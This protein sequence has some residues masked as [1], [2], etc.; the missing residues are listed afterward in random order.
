[1]SRRKNHNDK[2]PLTPS[3]DEDLGDIQDEYFISNES[4]KQ[5]REDDEDLEDI[6]DEDKKCKGC[7]PE[8]EN[9]DKYKEVTYRCSNDVERNLHKIRK[10]CKQDTAEEIKQLKAETE[11][12]YHELKNLCFALDIK[13]ANTRKIVL[14][15]DFLTFVIAVFSFLLCI[16]SVIVGCGCSHVENCACVKNGI[17]GWGIASIVLGILSLVSSIIVLALNLIIRKNEANFGAQDTQLPNAAHK[18][19]DISSIICW[20]ITAVNFIMMVSI[21]LI[22]FCR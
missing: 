22:I 5:R 1:M 16:A 19:N 9:C 13:I 17:S 3:D 6:Q 8:C 20:T 7:R 15:T 2:R 12:Q 21:V 4:D 14:A 10:Q 18:K 11:N